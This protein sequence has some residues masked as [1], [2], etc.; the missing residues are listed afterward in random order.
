MQKEVREGEKEGSRICRDWKSKLCEDYPGGG[1]GRQ[2]RCR[3]G[4][5][6]HRSKIFHWEESCQGS[7]C[8]GILANIGVLLVN[9][10]GIKGTVSL[11]DGSFV[12]DRKSVI[13]S[14]LRMNWQMLT[15]LIECCCAKIIP[16]VL[17]RQH[18]WGPVSNEKRSVLCQMT[19]SPDDLLCNTATCH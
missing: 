10:S 3:P 13:Q 7:T 9:E 11:T 14:T 5:N 4:S 15:L 8:C 1:G 16:A 17:N 6:D 18:H 19:R 12:V 2:H